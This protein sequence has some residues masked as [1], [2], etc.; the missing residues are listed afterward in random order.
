M[1]TWKSRG[2]GGAG[3]AGGAPFPVYGAPLMNAFWDVVNASGASPAE[4]HAFVAAHGGAAVTFA[5]N[6]AIQDLDDTGFADTTRSALE[7]PGS[8][9][10]GICAWRSPAPARTATGQRPR[11]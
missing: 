4:A 2:A 8:E 9:P 5:A 3:G 11:R 1:S 6:I 7:P 10:R